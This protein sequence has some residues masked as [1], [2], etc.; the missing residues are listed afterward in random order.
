MTKTI[1]RNLKKKLQASLENLTPRQSGRL[2]L[3]L[4]HEA[5]DK[6]V[7]AADYPPIRDLDA[8]WDRRL[9]RAK[10]KETYA[11]E[12]RLWNGYSFLRN[13]VALANMTGSSDVWR[14]LVTVTHAYYTLDRLLLVDSFSET[15]R[16]VTSYVALGETMPKPASHEEYDRLTVW[17][18]GDDVDDLA[19][20]A[21]FMAEAWL[22]D[23]YDPPEGADEDAQNQYETEVEAAKQAEFEAHLVALLEAGELEGGLAVSLHNNDD[24]LLLDDARTIPAWAA[25][26]AAWYGWL[27]DQGYRR[28][29]HETPHPQALAGVNVIY[30]AA[31]E[32]EGDDLAALAGDFLKDCK[33]RVWGR[34]LPAPKSVD[35][36]DLGFFLTLGKET[37]FPF[38]ADKAPDLGRVNWETFRQAEPSAIYFDGEPYPVATVRSLKAKV[39]GYSGHFWL[40]GDYYPTDDPEGRRRDLARILRLTKAMQVSHR[41]FTYPPKVRE[42]MKV[43][44]GELADYLGVEFYTP[45][46]QAVRDLGETFG[47]VAAFRRTYDILAD[48]YFGGLPLLHKDTRELLDQ[49]D[50]ILTTAETN[51]AA[52]LEALQE[53]PWGVDV[54]S[55]QLVKSEVDEETARRHADETVELVMLRGQFKRN[56]LDLGPEEPPAKDNRP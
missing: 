20:V 54:T 23:N 8:A 4:Y 21:Q 36:A 43:M 52:W 6:N 26:R 56:N 7:Y 46:E 22:E 17:V 28:H 32:V 40:L 42:D 25:L 30:N 33:K 49:A 29:E 2:F 14:H 3:L 37:P 19:G 18:E 53:W 35:L 51:L 39:E 45:L 9:D 16:L 15:A 24:D 11:Q 34:N 5:A 27:Y 13:L 38:L 12:V 55:L 44:A 1:P 48:E 41:A 50:T 10:G 31:G 47:R